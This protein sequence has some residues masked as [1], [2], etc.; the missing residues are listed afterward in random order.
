M[1]QTLKRKLTGSMMLTAL[2]VLAVVS[3]C[4]LLGMAR[5]SSAQFENE[6]ASA[7]T[8]EVLE[9]MNSGATGTAEGAAYNVEEILSAY[10]GRLRFG[11]DRSYSIW[12]AST[13]ELLAGTEDAQMTDNVVTA[14]SGAVGN[15]APLFPTKMDIAIP[16]SGEIPL[17]VDIVDNGS[18]MQTMFANMLMLLA[19]GAVLSLLMCL[20]LGFIMAEAFVGS[21]MQAAK[22]IR[23]KNDKSL[24]P[25]GDWEAMASALH[26]PTKAKPRKGTRNR[27]ALDLVLPYLRE[28][29]VRFDE[30]GDI[31]EINAAAEELLGVSLESEGELT[32]EM[33]FQGVPMPQETQSMVR[34]KLV[35]ND[36]T[37]DVVFIAI[38]PG[39]FAA[40]LYPVDG[41]AL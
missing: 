4:L 26:A 38:E 3:V 30:E 40:I 5:Y 12:E 21:A 31:L 27:D 18:S 15:A 23:E 37:L 17:V 11:A 25:E 29:Y 35:Q 2:A 16:V 36:R 41:R 6:V 34:G 32:F 13:G 28:G 39:I 19:V 22:S 1:Q 33:T 10:A 8:V 14:M 24:Y 20:F 7:L 9:E